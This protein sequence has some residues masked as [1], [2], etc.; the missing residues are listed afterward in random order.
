MVKSLG[1]RG[2]I[3]V[4]LVAV[5]LILQVTNLVW[6]AALGGLFGQAAIAE[7]KTLFG[8][9]LA[10]SVIGGRA[11]PALLLA[12]FISFLVWLYRAQSNLQAF[13]APS[14][15][16]PGWAVAW[17]FVP[18]INLVRPFQVLSDL[19]GAS[20]PLQTDGTPSGAWLI[21]LW[22]VCWLVTCLLPGFILVTVL[23]TGAT[24]ERSGPAPLADQFAALTT[25]TLAVRIAMIVALLCMLAYCGRIARWQEARRL[26]LGL[27]RV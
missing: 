11:L 1:G 3:V 17:W 23:R 20:R 5:V 15:W 27:A 25:T 2:R 12:C 16:T 8:V 21:R 7:F 4:L 22:W 6:L 14:R 10:I 9:I 19:Q 18:L 26:E 24:A 13:G